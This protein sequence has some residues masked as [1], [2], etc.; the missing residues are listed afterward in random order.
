MATYEPVTAEVWMMITG[1][2]TVYHV[3]T[4]TYEDLHL[5][6]GKLTM[7]GF[8]TS[9]RELVDAVNEVMRDSAR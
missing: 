8:E 9:V 5:D 2:D 6:D 4:V 7:D 1:S 3:G